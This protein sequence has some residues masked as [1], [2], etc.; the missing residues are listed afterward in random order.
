[1]FKGCYPIFKTIL[2]S[3]AHKCPGLA[4][5]QLAAGDSR[6]KCSFKV[7]CLC[8]LPE[9]L[10][11]QTH[12]LESYEPIINTSISCRLW[13]LSLFCGSSTG[14]SQG[15]HAYEAVCVGK[16]VGEDMELSNGDRKRKT[17]A[18]VLVLQSQLPNH[19]VT[20]L[21]NKCLPGH[22]YTRLHI[23][24][25]QVLIPVLQT[26]GRQQIYATIQSDLNLVDLAVAF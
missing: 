7:N 17:H 6:S 11:K 24:C 26:L 10:S 2:L 19:I 14:F 4:Q 5:I 1:M 8:N 12:Q 16:V 23:T 13:L 25:R 15:P 20:F 21:L 22:Y 9:Q 3:R 18:M